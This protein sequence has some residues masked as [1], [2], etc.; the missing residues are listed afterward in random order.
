MPIGSSFLI[1]QKI[2][3][4]TFF[5]ISKVISLA[6]LKKRKKQRETTPWENHKQN[7][8]NHEKSLN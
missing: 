1:T 3:K 8:I 6:L 7:K 5:V 4:I 2:N